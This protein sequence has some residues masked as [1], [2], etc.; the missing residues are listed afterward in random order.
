MN[1]NNSYIRCFYRKLNR[2][3][4]LKAWYLLTKQLTV[5]VKCFMYFRCHTN[6]EA[7]IPLLKYGDIFGF[8]K[9]V[10]SLVKKGKWQP[11]E[12]IWTMEIWV[13]NR[14]IVHNMKSFQRQLEDLIKYLFPTVLLSQLN[15]LIALEQ[16]LSASAR[17]LLMHL[18]VF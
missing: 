17:A 16:G 6:A 13:F 3:I 5:S 9:L 14:C 15:C 8:W 18:S 11:L 1:I 7:Y 12:E 10:Q 4:I 2:D